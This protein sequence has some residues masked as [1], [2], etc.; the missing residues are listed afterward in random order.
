M[1][2]T[3]EVKFKHL[4]KAREHIIHAKSKMKKTARFCLT[5]SSYEINKNSRKHHQTRCFFY[6]IH[7]NLEQLKKS[8]LPK[9]LEGGACTRL[10]S[11]N[12]Y[13]FLVELMTF[14][15][16]KHAA[17]CERAAFGDNTI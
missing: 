11:F 10:W 12:Q 4:A 17:C 8:L 2:K 13:Y 1:Q 5:Q 15:I 16:T 7:N 3:K 14:K 9:A 6:H